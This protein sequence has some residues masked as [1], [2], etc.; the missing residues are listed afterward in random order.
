MK[1]TPPLVLQFRA[2][3]SSSEENRTFAM[4]LLLDAS[5]DPLLWAGHGS[6]RAFLEYYSLGTWC[7]FTAF[8][9]AVDAFGMTAVKTIGA[10]IAIRLR[11][12]PESVRPGVVRF[13]IGHRRVHG[14]FASA[15]TVREQVRKVLPKRAPKARK[16]IEALRTENANLARQLAEAKAALRRSENDRALLRASL[17]QLQSKRSAQGK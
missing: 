9:A 1:T 3:I 2:R 7:A 10:S 11:S 17:A 8:R 14:E 5:K 15:A 6:F 16:G 13:A 4:N 12:V